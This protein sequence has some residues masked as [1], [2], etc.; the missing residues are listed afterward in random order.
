MTLATLAAL[1][2]SLPRAA[3]AHALDPAVLDVRETQAG[4]GLGVVLT[5]TLP[6]PTTLAAPELGFPLPEGCVSRGTTHDVYP[7]ATLLEL[8]ALC[9]ASLAARSIELPRLA[10]PDVPVLVRFA[11]GGGAPAVK[12]AQP[13]HHVVELPALTTREARGLAGYLRLGLEHVAF[14]WDHLALLV[15]LALSARRV[16]GGDGLFARVTAFTAAHGLVLGGALV[17]LASAPGPLVEVLVAASITV[18]AASELRA[19][20]LVAP[21]AMPRARR[22]AV[23]LA[24]A[25]GLLHGAAFASALEAWGTPRDELVPALVGL[26]LGVELAQAALAG[27]VFALARGLGSRRVERA[28]LALAGAAGACLAVMRL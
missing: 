22:G 4:E 1:G 20:R 9:A 21:P 28:A 17:G 27:L 23:R 16:L 18:L 5:L 7:E 25:L 14:G 24:F 13:R 15:C 2:L 3:H 6:T 11:R 12:L 19:R 10:G 26:N 8:R